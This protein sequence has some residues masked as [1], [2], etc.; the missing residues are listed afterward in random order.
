[1]KDTRTDLLEK[2]RELP[3]T[4][5]VVE[6]IKEAK[7][8]EYH[9]YKNKK[10]VCGKMAVIDKLRAELLLTNDADVKGLITGIAGDVMNGEYDEEADAED[11]EEMRK[12][13]PMHLWKAFKLD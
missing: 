3:Q 11:I 1:M 13:T 4:P 6:M 9:D 12:N 5:G 2:L 7:D 8:G 10:Y